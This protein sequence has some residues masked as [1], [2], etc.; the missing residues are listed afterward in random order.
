MEFY[1]CHSQ[2]LPLDLLTLSH[3]PCN[4]PQ[5]SIN[6]V[7]GKSMW[8]FGVVCQEAGLL[9]PSLPHSPGTSPGRK[10]VQA[11]EI[12]T[13]ENQKVSIRK[14]LIGREQ[15]NLAEGV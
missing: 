10:N 15:E 6:I 4:P 11:Q 14:S 1:I 8:C 9:T 2:R 13:L 12:N 3:I 5:E 7:Q